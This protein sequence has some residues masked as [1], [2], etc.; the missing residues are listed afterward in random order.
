MEDRIEAI[1]SAILNAS[2]NSV[3][4][5]VGKGSEAYQKIGSQYIPYKPDS[6]WA[7]HFLKELDTETEPAE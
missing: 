4:L 7:Q 6:Y 3:I 1:R 2:E 5:I